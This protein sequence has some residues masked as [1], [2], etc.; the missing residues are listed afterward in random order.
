MSGGDTQANRETPHE[1]KP[2]PE[3]GEA[4][5]H[6]LY[7]LEQTQ[8][9][10]N[11]RSG[12]N[13]AVAIGIGLVL[14]LIFLLS[15]FLVRE[16]FLVFLVVAI[17]FGTYEFS[18]ALRAQDRD[19]PRVA[20]ILGTT[21]QVFAAY[22][23]GSLG[24]VV[25]LGSAITLVVLWRTVELSRPSH[26][27]GTAA[28][29]LDYGAGI[30]V[31]VYLGFMLSFAAL[32]LRHEAGQWWILA[33]V[34]TVVVIDTSALFAGVLWG[35]HKFVP[36][37]SPSKTWEGFAGSLVGGVISGVL[38]ALFA[39]GQPWWVGVILGL[40]LVAS[41][42]IGDLTE[43][44]MKRDLGIKDMSSFLPGHG[45]FMD[46]LDSMLPSCVMA[47]IVFSACVN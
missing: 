30:L 31:Q 20:S 43:S 22:Y 36:K 21:A 33:F 29:F 3:F 10:I 12:R 44:L 41:A 18:T 7:Q 46:R 11:K 13:L 28:L 47:Y 38:F 19:V 16:L 26:R 42:T 5:R 14:G 34:V 6:T 27:T 4:L 45:G 9:R 25:A 2:P 1:P 32:L 24:Q 40:S 8:E 35:R 39:L 23:F 17:A 37:I 15:L